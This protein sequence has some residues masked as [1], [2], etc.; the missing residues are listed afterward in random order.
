M[1]AARA[2]LEQA[3]ELLRINEFIT[4]GA[5]HPKVIWNARTVFVLRLGGEFR[6]APEEFPHDSLSSLRK[7][8]EA[9]PRATTQYSIPDSPTIGADLAPGIPATQ[10][11]GYP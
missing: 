2:H 10:D 7:R 9:A 8:P 11:L 6:L 5:F 4:F 3:L 1:L